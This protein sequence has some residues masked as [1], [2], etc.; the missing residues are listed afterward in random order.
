LF[1]Q[2]VMAQSSKP[3][4]VEASN[5]AFSISGALN[6]VCSGAFSRLATAS[7]NVQHVLLSVFF[8]IPKAAADYPLLNSSNPSYDIFIASPSNDT[9]VRADINDF[10]ADNFG[11]FRDWQNRAYQIRMSRDHAYCAGNLSVALQ[12]VGAAYAASSNGASGLL[13]LIPTAG[14]LIGAPARELWVLYKLMPIAGLLS[15][16]ISLGGNIVPREVTD[17]ERVDTFSYQGFVAT[18]D[19]Q[20]SD[21]VFRPTGET[22]AEHFASEVHRRALDFR[23]KRRSFT[24]WI[25]ITLQVFWLSCILAACWFLESGT[26]ITWWCTVSLNVSNQGLPLSA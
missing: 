11:F 24:V 22:E 14:A 2:F 8:L 18:A 5:Q 9:T 4:F 13:T 3:C 19:H 20:T 16:T 1:N 23:G 15:M 25:G 6:W 10:L 17:F 26:V 12:D 7:S 21:P